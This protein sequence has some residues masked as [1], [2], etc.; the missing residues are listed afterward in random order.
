MQSSDSA[1]CLPTPGCRRRPSGTRGSSNATSAAGTYAQLPHSRYALGA[2]CSV[3]CAALC[4]ACAARLSCPAAC[5]AA[6]GSRASCS[7]Y[8]SDGHARKLTPLYPCPSECR[9]TFFTGTTRCTKKGMSA[10]GTPS[11]IR[12]KV[13]T[14]DLTQIWVASMLHV[15][16]K[17]MP[18]FSARGDYMCRRHTYMVLDACRLSDTTS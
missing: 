11:I 9:R 13:K 16:H 3:Q 8:G 2:V 5:L 12:G 1:V 15:M 7:D 14:R 17:D 18:A 10:Q 6:G 4:P